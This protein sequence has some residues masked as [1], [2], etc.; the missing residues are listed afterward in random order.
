MKIRS[1]IIMMWIVV[2]TMLSSMVFAGEGTV[3]NKIVFFGDS[4]SDNGNLYRT[5][6]GFMPKS[7]PYFKGRFSNGFVWSDIVE[8]YFQSSKSITSANYAV[9][10]E[11]SVLH[12]PIKGYLPYSLTASLDSYLLRNLRQNK[13]HTLFIIFIG[14]NDYLTGVSNIDAETSKVIA[15]VKSAID[16]LIYYGGKNFLVINLPDLSVTPE[17]KVRNNGDTLKIVTIAHN[18]K[19]ADLVA[20]TEQSYKQV[21][22]QLY[23]LNEF[24]GEMFSNLKSF[25]EKHQVDL[26][27]NTSF[28]WSG[29]YSIKN[30][31][32]SNQNS[33]IDELATEN[34][35][36]E[37]LSQH[38]K[39]NAALHASVDSNAKL[40]VSEFAHYVATNPDL[41]EAYDISELVATG[42]AIP[43]ANPDQYVFWDHIHPT[44]VVH[45]LLADK[46]IPFIR[47]H[48]Q[49]SAS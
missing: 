7:P 47:Q 1:L 48:Y 3:I 28:C 45:K 46:M 29:G 33:N 12:N 22:I 6:L 24:F 27:N 13:D 2:F 18:K 8:E 44:A 31:L 26:A 43:C 4:L 30:H 21:N 14:G 42:R 11:T 19:L 15:N 20:E 36:A 40:D 37:Q 32:A 35:I 39:Q 9:G 34:R 25:N 5:D 41:R 38:L 16:R 10:G 17:S 49:L 23:D